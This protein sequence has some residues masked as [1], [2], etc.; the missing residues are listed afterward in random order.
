MKRRLWIDVLEGDDISVLDGRDGRG[1]SPA[2]IL[3]N[4]QSVMRWTLRIDNGTWRESPADRRA[5]A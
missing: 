5:I 2:M 4:R 1:I 3:Q